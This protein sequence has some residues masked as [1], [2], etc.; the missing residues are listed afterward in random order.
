[1]SQIYAARPFGS[2]P[3]LSST[4]SC[5]F[6]LPPLSIWVQDGAELP[7]STASPISYSRSE[8][9]RSIVE[10]EKSSSGQFTITFT[11]PRSLIT[12]LDTQFHRLCLLLTVELTI[13]V[14]VGSETGRGFLCSLE[15]FAKADLF[16]TR[17]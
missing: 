9:G 17:D 4:L 3:T 5:R 7:T 13:M 2:K 8:F 12:Y 14:A 6:P 1:M 11:S 15:L 10:V 16:S